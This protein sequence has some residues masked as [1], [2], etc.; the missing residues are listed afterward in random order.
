VT[1]I[2]RFVTGDYLAPAGHRLAGQRIVP[3]AYLIRHPDATI[4]FD[5][6]FPFDEPTTLNE[7]D[8]AIETYP[9]SLEEALRA[10]G[11]SLVALDLVANCHLH[12]DHAGGNFRLPAHLPIYAQE[13]ELAGARDEEESIVRDALALGRQS[14]RSIDGEH[15]LVPGVLLVPTPGHT[16]GHQSLIVE[17]ERG[18]VVLAG[19]AVQSAT[20]YAAAVYALRLQGEGND[21]VPPYPSWLPRLTAIEPRRVMFGHDLSIWEADA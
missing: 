3:V 20:E 19:Q 4:L 2:S 15:E 12:I 17:T 11:A 8:D 14:Y 9:R 18:T 21:P 13:V 10:S 16:P 6:G 1:S 7:G 5:T